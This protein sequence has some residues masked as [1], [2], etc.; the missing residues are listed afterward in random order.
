ML[1][2]M[3]IQNDGDRKVAVFL[4]GYCHC[5][6]L[7]L[8]FMKEHGGITEVIPYLWSWGMGARKYAFQLRHLFSEYPW[9]NPFVMGEMSEFPNKE[10]LSSVQRRPYIGTDLYAT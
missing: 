2:I 4:L 5:S 8:S 6:F 7:I 10:P 1:G 9:D 3:F